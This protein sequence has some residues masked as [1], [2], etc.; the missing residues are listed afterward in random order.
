MGFCSRLGESPSTWKHF[1][2][3]PTQVLN[4]VILDLLRQETATWG[5]LDLGMDSGRSDGFWKKDYGW[6]SGHGTPLAF[7]R[8]GTRKELCTVR[9]SVT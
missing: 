6:G 3:A 2:P 9:S 5:G 4:S 7:W 1:G 8:T